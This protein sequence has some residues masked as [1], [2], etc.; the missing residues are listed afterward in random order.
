MQPPTRSTVAATRLTRDGSARTRLSKIATVIVHPSCTWWCN[1]TSRSRPRVH[2]IRNRDGTPRSAL[3]VRLEAV[4]H[5]RL[6]VVTLERLRGGVRVALLHLLLLRGRHCAVVLQALRHER[7]ALVAF[8]VA[9]LSVAGLH[10]LLLR[11]L[12]LLIRSQSHRAGP[13]DE[14]E[15]DDRSEKCL[16][17][18]FLSARRRLAGPLLTLSKTAVRGQSR[19]RRHC[20]PDGPT[21]GEGRRMNGGR[22]RARTCDPGLVR[23][24]LS[25]L[26]Y[27]PVSW[28]I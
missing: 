14:R 19:V 6:A 9:R 15:R 18:P 17:E 20:W 16:H 3:L 24:V 1:D 10:A 12:L 23:A 22:S 13:C 11:V 8:L 4:A 28:V 7:L 5:E 27:P 2:G 26:S 25:Q 21:G